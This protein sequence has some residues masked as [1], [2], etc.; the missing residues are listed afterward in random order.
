MIIT[1]TSMRPLTRVAI[2]QPTGLSPSQTF[3]PKLRHQLST[4]RPHI[5]EPFP[6]SRLPLFLARGPPCF[7]LS[8]RA[9]RAYELLHLSYAYGQ[10]RN[11]SRSSAA[12]AAVVT[13]NP[14]NDDEGNEMLI[15][16]TPRAASVRIRRYTC[17]M[18]SGL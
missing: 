15:D 6:A 8:R 14:R 13:A 18:S 16:I 7:Y 5:N 3:Q 2:T 17:S 12:K 1:R 9:D 10:V 11:L 4:Y